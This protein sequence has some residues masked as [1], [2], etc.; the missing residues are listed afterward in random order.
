MMERKVGIVVLQRPPIDRARLDA[1]LTS[2]LIDPS[3]L[4][5]DSFDEFMMARQKRLLKLIEQAIGKSIYSGN[6]KEEGD[7]AEVD[8]DTVEAELTIPN[9]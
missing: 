7:D 1:Y 2:H 9:A 5:T 8:E 6:I 4:R 3:P